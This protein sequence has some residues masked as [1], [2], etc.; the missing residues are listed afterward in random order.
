MITRSFIRTPNLNTP[1]SGLISP[2]FDFRIGSY[3]LGNRESYNNLVEG[4]QM[5]IKGET[6]ARMGG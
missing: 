4:V 1:G 5:K 6:D 2:G 3:D